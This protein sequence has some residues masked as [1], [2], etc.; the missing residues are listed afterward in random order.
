MKVDN[1]DEL[2]LD[3]GDGAVIHVDKKEIETR[4]K[5]TSAMPPDI[6]K[7]LSKRDLRNLVEFLANLKGPGTG[8]ATAVASPATGTPAA[9]AGHPQGG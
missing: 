5:G 2:V 7:P 6:A 4:S 3:A 1:G 9:A 8:P